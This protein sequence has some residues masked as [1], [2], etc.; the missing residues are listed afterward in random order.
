MDAVRNVLWQHKACWTVRAAENQKPTLLRAF[1]REEPHTLGCVNVS[2]SN[3]GNQ[4]RKILKVSVYE[5]TAIFVGCLGCLAIG[6][7]CCSSYRSSDKLI[8]RFRL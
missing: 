3:F 1:V 5:K 7:P 6:G 2:V 4:V 8:L